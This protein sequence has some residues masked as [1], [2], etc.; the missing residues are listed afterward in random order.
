M[1]SS[2]LSDQRE[3]GW[4][5]RTNKFIHSPYLSGVI[6]RLWLLAVFQSITVKSKTPRWSWYFCSCTPSPSPSRQSE[7]ASGHV[8]ATRKIVWTVFGF[9]TISPSV[10]TTGTRG[11]RPGRAV[12]STQSP[13][14][15]VSSGGNTSS[16]RGRENVSR[17]A[18][19]PP[20]VTGLTRP[21]RPPGAAGWR[22]ARAGEDSWQRIGSHWARRP[23]RSFKTS[24]RKVAT[25]RRRQRG[26]AGS[27]H[28]W[29]T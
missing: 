10:G 5:W 14:V 2:V 3:G 16:V 21:P 12:T 1:L 28:A 23:K 19:R 22:A 8:K 18:R 15:S 11:R 9:V 25:W 7:A 13:G 6:D 24:W 26:K 20:S 4:R 27:G 29:P 17:P